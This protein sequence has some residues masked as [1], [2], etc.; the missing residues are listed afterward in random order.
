MT[1]Q[2][3]YVF[4]MLFNSIVH[5]YACNSCC[6]NFNLGVDVVYRLWNVEACGVFTSGDHESF[7]FLHC[8]NLFL[9]R[10]QPSWKQSTS[11]CLGGPCSEPLHYHQSAGGV[12]TSPSPSLV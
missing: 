9:L 11:A 1:I 4:H 3:R 6:T 2:D 10:T 5:I 7:Q 8:W 12:D